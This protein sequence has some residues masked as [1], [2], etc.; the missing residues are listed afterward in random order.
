MKSS[1][2]LLQI[3]ILPLIFSLTLLA[4]QDLEVAQE[5][6]QSFVKDLSKI[7]GISTIGV[8]QLQG[9]KKGL[10][11]EKIKEQLITETKY[12]IIEIGIIREKEENQKED[13]N[14]L[15][16]ALREA[17]N[18]GIDAVLSGEI[19]SDSIKNRNRN[20]IVGMQLIKVSDNEI[21]YNNTKEFSHTLNKKE[22]KD[23]KQKTLLI[24]GG[25]CVIGIILVRRLGF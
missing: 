13:L 9:D 1:I 14:T 15:E 7:S 5:I 17:K 12:K 18:K 24:V 20:I 4:D 2:I 3:I 10:V 22:F 6:A 19:K 11:T 23:N 16:M 25:L 21:L 8:L